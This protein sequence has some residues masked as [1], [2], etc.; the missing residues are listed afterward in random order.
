M[1][2]RGYIFQGLLMN[3]TIF[4]EEVEEKAC[5]FDFEFVLFAWDGGN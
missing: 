5:A 3:L 4:F 2:P 1:T